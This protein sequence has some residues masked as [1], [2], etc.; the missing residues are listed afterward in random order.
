MVLPHDGSTLDEIEAG[1]GLTLE[2]YV[3]VREYLKSLDAGEADETWLYSSDPAVESQRRN[4]SIDLISNQLSSYQI[5]SGQTSSEQ[6]GQV[7]EFGAGG[8]ASR[9]NPWLERPRS[10]S[11]H[12]SNDPVHLCPSPRDRS[13]PQRGSRRRQSRYGTEF[14]V[15]V[16]S[17]VV[18]LGPGESAHVQFVLEGEMN[19]SEAYDITL[20]SQTLVSPQDVNWRL[21]LLISI[22]RRMT[23]RQCECESGAETT[24]ADLSL[25]LVSTTW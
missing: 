3:R 21:V 20:G 1:P 17:I 6:G 13:T 25:S 8:R 5:A 7:G 18:D 23:C 12:E 16:Y 22:R 15:G 4:N 11:G 2:K 14:G 10:P 19:S 24:A 9:C